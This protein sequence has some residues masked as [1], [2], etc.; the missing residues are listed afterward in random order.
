MENV[1]GLFTSSASYQLRGPFLAR[2]ELCARVAKIGL[3]ARS[4]LG[5]VFELFV[6]YFRVFGHKPCCVSDLKIYLKLL[7]PHRRKEL[8]ARLLKDAGI[9]A[10]TLPQSVRLDARFAPPR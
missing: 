2:L 1:D 3:D 9:S 8:A 4:L 7:E 6:E 5:D 10:T